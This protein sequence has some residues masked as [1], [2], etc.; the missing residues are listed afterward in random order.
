MRADNAV[1]PTK[2]EST[3]VTWVCLARGPREDLAAL[4]NNGDAEGFEALLW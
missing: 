4:S 2:S 3:T 1:N